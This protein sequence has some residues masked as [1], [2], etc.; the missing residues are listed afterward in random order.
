MW[1]A[2]LGIPP[3][4]HRA[5]PAPDQPPTTA[6]RADSP[7]YVPA[8]RVEAR[9]LEQIVDAVI[10]DT[11]PG[12]DIRTLPAVTGARRLIASTIDQLQV[13]TAADWLTNPR[14]YGSPLDLGD[15]IQHTVDGMLLHGRAFWWVTWVTGD[16]SAPTWRIEPLDPGIVDVQRPRYG[17]PQRRF[18]VA[19]QEGPTEEVPAVFAQLERGRPYLLHIPYIVTVERPEGTTPLRESETVLRG[20]LDTEAHTSELFASG[21]HI[22]GM[23]TTEHD[24][25]PG[26]AKDWQTAWIEARRAKRIPVLGNGLVYRNDVPSARDLQM[27]EARSFNQSVVWALLGIPMAYM[28]SSL[29]GGQSS[30]SYANAQDNRRQFADNCLR[31]FTTQMEDAMSRLTPPSQPVKFDYMEW[32]GRA[33]DGTATTPTDGIPSA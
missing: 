29:M 31:A 32:E 18:V 4:T 28:G 33:D 30:L 10:W 9:T 20:L 1:K 15:T 19:G 17:W 5:G 22:G 21:T 16:Q 11:T 6:I 12:R 8:V 25:T 3:E 23:L 14:R 24:I 26:Q 2:L 7:S 27:V 13:D